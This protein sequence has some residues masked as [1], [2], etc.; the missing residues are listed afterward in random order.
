L[1]LLSARIPPLFWLFVVAFNPVGAVDIIVDYYR[2][3]QVG[4]PVLAGELGATYWIPI[5]YVPAL[6]ITHVVALYLLVRPQPNAARAFAADAA[7]C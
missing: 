5:L 7:A 1:A 2:G 6:M 3:N 4:L